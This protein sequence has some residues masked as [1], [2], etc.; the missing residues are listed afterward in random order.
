MVNVVMQV[1]LSWRNEAMFET[2]KQREVLSRSCSVG[3]FGFD[4]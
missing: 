3:L 4:E 1:V 2:I